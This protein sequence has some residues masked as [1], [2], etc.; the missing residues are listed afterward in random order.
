MSTAEQQVSRSESIGTEA[1]MRRYYFDLEQGLE[2]CQDDVG[3]EFSDLDSAT[4]EMRR[5]LVELGKEIV[6]STSSWELYGTIRD[7]KGVL[8]RGRLS[9]EQDS[10]SPA[11]ATV[12]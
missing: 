9:F 4:A 6:D 10:T 7:D 1:P 12:V 2:I 11:P 3:M 8:W 5:T